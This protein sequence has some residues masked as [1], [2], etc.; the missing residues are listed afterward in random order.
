M[1]ITLKIILKISHLIIYFMSCELMCLVDP[2][3][4]FGIR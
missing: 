2:A 4:Y 3:I 1:K